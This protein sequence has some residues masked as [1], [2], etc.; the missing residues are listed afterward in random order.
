MTTE[1]VNYLTPETL[2]EYFRAG[3]TTVQRLSTN[4]PSRLRINPTAER[5]EL[6]VPTDGAEPDVT[7]MARLNVDTVHLDGS[8]WFQLQVDAQGIHHEAYSMLASI[9]DDMSCGH[10]FVTATSN[11]LRAYRDLLNQRK[12]LTPEQ[13]QGLI[14][15]LLTLRHVRDVLGPDVALEAWLGP[16]A[17]Q[18]D[19]GFSTFDVEVKTTTTEARSHL[20][21]SENQLQP[22]IGRSLWL[23]SVQLTRAGAPGS[24]HSVATLVGDLRS[25][26]E[27]GNDR[28]MDKLNSIGWRDAD[29]ELYLTPYILRSTPASYRVDDQFPAITRPRLKAAVP[30]PQL[31]G[32]VSYRIDLTTLDAAAPPEP[33]ASFIQEE[34][35]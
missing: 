13:Q 8:D 22:S 15:E 10:S 9:V 32:D 1:P 35:R 14:G 24:G 26:F 31:V 2:A 34:S 7:A 6:F 27:R 3:T 11:A 18:H 25:R 12:G 30:N 23:M 28:F 21:G 16:F 4:P 19:F 17:E 20:I 33:L 5:L 29:H